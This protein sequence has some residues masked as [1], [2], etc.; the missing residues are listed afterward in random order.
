MDGK[1][2]QCMGVIFL[3]INKLKTLN[4]TEFDSHSMVVNT[5]TKVTEPPL[6]PHSHSVD[7][8]S[9][10]TISNKKP[11]KILLKNPA[12]VWNEGQRERSFTTSP[13]VETPRE[14]KDKAD[15]VVILQAS[16]RGYLSRRSYNSAKGKLDGIEKEF[17]ANKNA[18]Q[19][20]IKFQAHVRSKIVW[21]SLKPKRERSN[22]AKEILSSEE[23]YVKSL[24]VLVSVYMNALE[25]LGDEIAPPPILRTIFSEVKVIL[26]Y[27]EFIYNG[28]KERM[29]NWYS[30][31]QRL[32][33]IFLRLT[34]FLKVYTAY[35]NNYNDAI[36]TLQELTQVEGVGHTLNECRSKP[37]TNGLDIQAYLIM[38][39][40]R[41]PRYV[42]LLNSL[43]KCTPSGHKDFEDLEKALKKMESVAEYVNQKKKEA[44]NLLG[45][46]TVVKHLVGMEHASEFN[47]PHRRYVRQ[48]PMQE[49]ENG[50]L[51]QKALKNRYVFLFNDSII[52]TKESTNILGKKK[53]LNSTLD[54]EGLKNSEIT[55]KVLFVEDL[56]GATVN[57]VVIESPKQVSA[58]EIKFL[59]G[60]KTCLALPNTQSRDDWIQD[61]DE[62]IMSCLE[63]RRSRLEISPT[64][65]K[66]ME[67]AKDQLK[68]PFLSGFLHRLG[69]K[70][71]WKKKYFVLNNDVLYC[72]NKKE[73]YKGGE[74]PSSIT[75]LLFTSVQ[76]HNVMD[77]PFCFRLLTKTR[78]YYFAASSW[79]DR[80]EWINSMRCMTAKHMD[81]VDSKVKLANNV[82]PNT[83][84]ADTGFTVASIMTVKNEKKKGDSKKKKSPSKPGKAE[85]KK[86]M[87]QEEDSSKKLDSSGSKKRASGGTKRKIK[88]KKSVS[89]RNKDAL[90]TISKNGELF[91]FSSETKTSKYSFTLNGKE[92]IY[93]RQGRTKVSGNISLLLV[94]STEN[95]EPVTL[96]G[97]TYYR[98]ALITSDRQYILGSTEEADTASWVGDINTALSMLV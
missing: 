38:P 8:G 70:G 91:K 14:P 43:Y 16:I 60:R 53:T 17:L 31:G 15:Y 75:H 30:E 50:V 28:I 26:S 80:M 46:S 95:L 82:Q 35:V 48:G 45:V 22:I 72:F 6:R 21:D 78:I 92:L 33:D 9:P 83:V 61:I 40:Q 29:E 94:Q 68:S 3:L 12:K 88:R 2:T 19:G 18:M 55:F 24:R 57:E 27:N 63:K 79:K 81:D 20:L 23:T 67:V 74:D 64:E 11:S 37:E 13:V 10:D 96:K 93:F 98:F 36:K 47:Q 86:E 58:F 42:L 49:A 69:Q 51:T 62:M 52:C 39:I 84:I 89:R 87:P 59:S 97:V 41:I 5:H 56:L 71:D 44:E 34:D 54:I 25:S 32:G 90:K 1:K 66:V 76:Y 7:L 85:D 65:E 73:D 4:L 77:R